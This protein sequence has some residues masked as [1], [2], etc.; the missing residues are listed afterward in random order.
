MME[1][2]KELED[3]LFTIDQEYEAQTERFK[4]QYD[5][6]MQKKLE[7]AKERI[8]VDYTYNLEIKLEEQKSKM[9]QEKYEFVN[10]LTGDKQQEL[11]AL[12]LRQT[13]NDELNKKLETALEESKM[14][15][16]RLRSEYNKKR[17][18]WPF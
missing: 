3:R 9:L 13:Q 6:K 18:W 10:N 12:R 1:K 7:E 4:K 8:K 16:D 14:E 5:V 11:V 15:L 17:R 2:M